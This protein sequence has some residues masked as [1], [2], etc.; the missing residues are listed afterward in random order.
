MED[1]QKDPRF[2]GIEARGRNARELVA[3]LD[4]RLMTKTRE[5][6]V[7]ILSEEG[8][9]FTPI[10]TPLEVSK[11]SQALANR[12]FIDVDHPHWGRTRMVGFPWDFSETPASWQREAPALGQHTG[13][14]L[15]E[16]GYTREEIARFRAEGAIQ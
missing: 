4:Q 7:C 10:Q 14:I 9:I 12:Y 5:E 16:A 13:E 2:M 8:C 6:W 11:D 3:L 1:I 15:S